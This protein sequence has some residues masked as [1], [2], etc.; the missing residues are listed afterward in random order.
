MC[1]SDLTK[2]RWLSALQPEFTS[3]LFNAERS[4]MRIILR[5]RERQSAEDKQA[6]IDRVNQ[7]T[8]IEFPDAR[9]TGLFVLLSH[10]LESLLKTSGLV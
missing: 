2:A 10:L 4:R 3:S 7:L 8:L 1:S 9:V 6:L 5:A